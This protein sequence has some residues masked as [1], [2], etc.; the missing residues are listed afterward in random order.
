V[1]PIGRSWRLDETYIKV[2]GKWTYYYRAVDKQGF[3]DH[4]THEPEGSCNG[5]TTNFCGYI[6]RLCSVPLKFLFAVLNIYL[7]PPE[8]HGLR[9]EVFPKGASDY[10]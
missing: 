1:I 2:K 4:C 5:A 7:P 9:L 6:L 3:G 8:F 10:A